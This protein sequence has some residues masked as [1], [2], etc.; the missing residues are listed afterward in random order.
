MCSRKPTWWRKSRRGPS[1]STVVPVGPSKERKS[2]SLSLAHSLFEVIWKIEGRNSDQD[3]RPPG[4]AVESVETSK[5]WTQEVKDYGSRTTLPVMVFE[6]GQ[7]PES[8]SHPRPKKCQA[9][10]Q[11]LGE[12]GGRGLK[13]ICTA[14]PKRWKRYGSFSACRRRGSSL[15]RITESV[16]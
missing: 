11:D 15:Q 3:C 13:T 6:L 9:R 10:Q 12:M 5:F 2:S 1:G 14:T 7:R 16:G 4:E 8:H